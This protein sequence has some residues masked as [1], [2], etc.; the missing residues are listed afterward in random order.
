MFFNRYYFSGVV[1]IDVELSSIDINQC[2]AP[3]TLTKGNRGKKGTRDR[4][5]KLLDFLGTHKCKPSTQV[6]HNTRFSFISL[7]SF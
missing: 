2:D 5:G 3:D 1:S 7:D 4:T 6:R